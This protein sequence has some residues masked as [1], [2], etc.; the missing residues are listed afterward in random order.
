MRGDAQ[1]RTAWITGAAQGIGAA[2]AE[3][4]A[5]PSTRIVLMDRNGDK[6]LQQQSLLRERGAEAYVC[7]VDLAD[8]RQLASSAQQTYERFGAA[9]ILVNNA[10]VAFGGPADQFP[11]DLW[12]A[13]FAVNVHAPFA[14][15]Q[16]C[17]PLMRAAGWG[18]IINIASVSG[19]RAGSGRL[20]YGTSKA[21]LIAMTQQI[22]IEAAT[23]GVTANAVA[24][25]GVETELAQGFHSAADR[26][27]ILGRI[28]AGRYGT[29]QEIASA[30][31]YLASNES[32]YVTGQT[33]A[34]DGGF[35][36]A[37]F[38]L[39]GR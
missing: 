10:G 24:P 2:I 30:V 29:V 35:S 39:G 37:G 6:L 11:A 4:L 21:A 22:A 8:P 12:H 5:G 38:L 31:A 36:C 13:T 20:A 23:W 34:V 16:F 17:L 7:T 19:L 1:A 32:S 28:P 15:T 14:L 26:D 25:G 33:L 27:R 18:R 3:R 9:D